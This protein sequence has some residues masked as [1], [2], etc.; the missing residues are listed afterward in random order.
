MA[1][2]SAYEWTNKHTVQPQQRQKNTYAHSHACQYEG[3]IANTIDSHRVIHLASQHDK[4]RHVYSRVRAWLCTNS[5]GI[6]RRHGGGIVQELF[7]GRKIGA[8]TFGSGVHTC[9]VLFVSALPLITNV[10]HSS[11]LRSAITPCW[12][13]LLR[14]SASRGFGR[15]SNPNGCE[16]S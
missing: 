6:G 15:C 4:V 2:T 5:I 16:R 8:R 3:T 13:L 11:A 1:S 9:R 14:K 7:R 12:R 10:V